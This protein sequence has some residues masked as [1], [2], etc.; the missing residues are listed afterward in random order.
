MVSRLDIL[1]RCIWRFHSIFVELR[2]VVGRGSLLVVRCQESTDA[3]PG[4]FDPYANEQERNDAENTMDKGGRNSLRDS[5]CVGTEH[6]EHRAQ[7]N[8]TESEPQKGGNAGAQVE[9]LC[10]GTQREYDCDGAGPDRNG[11]SE[12]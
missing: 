10:L 2:R 11:E 7:Q 1:R 8:N 5:G 3:V 6:I 12:G 4:N 9:I